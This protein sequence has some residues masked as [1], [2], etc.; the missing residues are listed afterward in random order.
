MS[1]SRTRGKPAQRP[2]TPFS[3]E[4]RHVVRFVQCSAQAPHRHTPLHS[5]PHP[6]SLT[7]RMAWLTVPPC[8]VRIS[9]AASA[10]PYRSAFGLNIDERR[11]SVRLFLIAPLFDVPW[12]RTFLSMCHINSKGHQLWSHFFQKQPTPLHL[13]KG[14]PTK[15]MPLS[16]SRYNAYFFSRV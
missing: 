14:C 9:S 5:S 15:T 6:L 2:S 12:R 13:D 16:N 11:S 4:L 10:S 7:P 8:R 1:R 3:D